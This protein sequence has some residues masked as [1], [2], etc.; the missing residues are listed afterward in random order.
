MDFFLPCLNYINEMIKWPYHTAEK[1]LAFIPLFLAWNYIGD[2]NCN[3]SLSQSFSVF[4]RNTGS[5]G[6][7][8]NPTKRIT[9]I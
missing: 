4:Q 3:N 8:I 9:N 2:D 5:K 7:I 6:R 1:W